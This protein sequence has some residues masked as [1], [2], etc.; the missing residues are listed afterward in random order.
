MSGDIGQTGYQCGCTARKGAPRSRNARPQSQPQQTCRRRSH[1]IC[2]RQR[3][4]LRIDGIGT[5]RHAPH[6]RRDAIGQQHRTCQGHV[7]RTRPEEDG[8]HSVYT[9]A[10]IGSQRRTAGRR[11]FQRYGRRPLC[12]RDS[13]Q[14]RATPAYARPEDAE[15][16]HPRRDRATHRH[17]LVQGAQHHHQGRRGRLGGGS[18]RLTA[19]ALDGR[20]SGQCHTQGCRSDIRIGRL[21]GGGIKCCHHRLPGASLG[22][23]P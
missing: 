4:R 22:K 14:T 6:R 7:Q 10:S 13:Q 23:C 12:P 20:G 5:G 2:A 18:Y 8:G 21:A 3:T 17:R 11:H 19:Q 16:H 1:R 15:T 9:C